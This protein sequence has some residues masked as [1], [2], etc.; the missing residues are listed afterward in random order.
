MLRGPVA[1]VA[2]L[3]IA[4]TACSS[5]SNGANEAGPCD[6][7][8][9]TVC[10]NEDLR[11]VSMVAAD[12]TGSD[13][14]GSDLRG[15]DL[16]QATLDDVKFVGSILGAVDFTDASLKNADLTKANLFGT[17]F[18]GADMSGTILTDSFSCNITSPDGALDPGN[19]ASAPGTPTPSLP[20]TPTPTGP[21]VI[22]VLKISPPGRCLNDSA[23][24]GIEID[25]VTR[26][27]TG[28]SFAVDGIRIDG[29]SKLRGTQ[30][31]PFVCDGKPHLVALQA[32]GA[33]GQIAT[34]SLSVALKETAPL[35]SDG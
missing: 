32:F 10:R 34:K 9:G 22:D 35:G 6:I 31:L 24:D 8:P 5:G 7:K 12:L 30:R 3:A 15:S 33:N 26:N 19:C 13:F 16:R 25:F 27:A 1:V 2:L 18:T 29:V 20:G 4:L 11:G 21:A 23:G 17:N 28:V 14:S